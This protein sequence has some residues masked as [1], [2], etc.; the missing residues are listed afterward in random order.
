MVQDRW[1]AKTHRIHRAAVCL[2]FFL[3]MTPEV[4]FSSDQL[5]DTF[6]PEVFVR[7]SGATTVIQRSFSIPSYF[8]PDWVLHIVN[9]DPSGSKRVAIEDAVSSGRVFVDGIEVVSPADFSK[10]VAVIDKPLSLGPGVHTI[11]VRLNSAPGSFIT[12]N[13]SGIIPLGDLT[14]ARSDHAA[15]LFSNGGVLI[16]GGKTPLGPLTSAEVSDPTTLQFSPLSAVL[17]ARRSGQSASVLADEN[18][19]LI[20]GEN[21]AGIL[22]STE[23]FNPSTGIFSD[24]N[25]ILRIPRTNHTAT[26]LLDGRVLITGGTGGHPPLAPIQ[27]STLTPKA[28]LFLS[29]RLTLQM[30]VSSCF[31]IYSRRPDGATPPPYCP[32]AASLF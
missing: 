2:L 10:T 4:C 13:I 11:E 21:D 14:Q 19:L 9:G 28:P 24:I 5:R 22:S 27:P 18:H 6:G 26:V 32:M 7:Q 16:A 31:Q 20:S 29:P 30:A 8:N 15:S 1:M 3:L 25:D 17:G 23:I 12:L